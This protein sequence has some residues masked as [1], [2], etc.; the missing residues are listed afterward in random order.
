M[1]H[2]ERSLAPDIARGFM[3][4]FIALVNVGIY[5][6]GRDLDATGHVADASFLDRVALFF[7]QLFAAERS[8]PMFA[9]LYGFG[10]AVMASRM[11][12]RGYTAKGVR[13]VLRRRSWWLLAFG[14]VHAVF[15]FQGD[16]LGAYGAT[17][18][19]ALGF[20]HLSDRALRRWMWGTF[21]WVTLTLGFILVAAGVAATGTDPGATAGEGLSRGYLDSLGLGVQAAITGP[22]LA[23]LTLAFVPLMILGLRLQRSGWLAHPGEHLESLRRTFRWGMVVNIATSLPVALSALGVWHPN[24]DQCTTAYGLTFVGGMWA[25]YGY[26]CGFALLAHRWSARGRHGLPGALAALGE[27]SLTGY[28]GQSIIMAPLLSLWGFGLGEGL[29]YLAA[30]CIA[31][32]AW[33][34]TLAV[35]VAMDRR[36]LRGPFEVVLRRLVYGRPRPATMQG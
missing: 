35:A 25:G 17:G 26:I 27:R 30:A 5:V 21:A 34:T 23:T 29:G 22:I 11:V 16:I 1:A 14:T 2:S 3:L 20:V 7:E 33:G 9:I 15:L 13:K 36:G 4:L 18:L 6:V 28:L 10:I 31:V 12:G 32:G 19:I 24:A 8:R